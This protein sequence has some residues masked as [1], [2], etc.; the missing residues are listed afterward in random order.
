MSQSRWQNG[1]HHESAN[2]GVIKI[3]TRLVQMGLTRIPPEFP[4]DGVPLFQ[5]SP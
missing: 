3:A 2:D 4:P 5:L 1:S